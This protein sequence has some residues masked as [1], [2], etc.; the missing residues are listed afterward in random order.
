MSKVPAPAL[1]GIASSAGAQ[2]AESA[3]PIKTINRISFI[4][5]LLEGA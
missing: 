2:A 4:G 3:A 5:S 1:E